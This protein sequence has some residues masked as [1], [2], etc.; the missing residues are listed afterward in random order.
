MKKSISILLIS[1]VFLGC[2]PKLKPEKPENLISKGKM[3]D[4]LHDMFIVS[5]AKG[6]NRPKLEKNGLNPELYILKKHSIDSLQFATSN[7]YYAHDVEA[8]KAIINEVK[9][10]LNT[11][12][13]KFVAIDKEEQEER[14]RIKDSIRKA[15]QV[16]KAN[17]NLETVRSNN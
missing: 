10:R 13:E 2:E 14:N 8:Y 3:V 11:E 6:V 1:I 9:V 15:K 5:S 12:K 16:Q 17:P 7:D 4:V